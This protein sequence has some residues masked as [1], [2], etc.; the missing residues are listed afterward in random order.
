M[1][2]IFIFQNT[3]LCIYKGVVTLRSL[4]Q[5]MDPLEN[6]YWKKKKAEYQKLVEELDSDKLVLANKMYLWHVSK[7]FLFI[8]FENFNNFCKLKEWEFDSFKELLNYYLEL[9]VATS[10]NFTLFKFLI[11]VISS[12]TL[13][14]R[15]TDEEY[16]LLCELAR[17]KA[18]F[19]GATS[20]DN[21]LYKKLIEIKQRGTFFNSGAIRGWLFHVLYDSNLL[22][23]N[24][25]WILFFFSD[26]LL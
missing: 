17:K 22:Q 23:L 2:I 18:L 14:L 7:A 19:R 25:N 21:F 24:W 20:R 15:C 5:L 8:S 13:L 9:F 10:C 3:S 12:K 26:S 1:G 16:F 4:A 11:K 6:P